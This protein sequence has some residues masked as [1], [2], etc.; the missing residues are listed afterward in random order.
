LAEPF[1]CH[2]LT[3]QIVFTINIVNLSFEISP[4]LNSSLQSVE[5]ISYYTPYFGIDIMP[6]LTGRTHQIMGTIPG[7][8]KGSFLNFKWT[9]VPTLYHYGTKTVIYRNDTIMLPY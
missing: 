7:S 9:T 1:F 4:P 2:S 5:E 6:K 8:K 3:K